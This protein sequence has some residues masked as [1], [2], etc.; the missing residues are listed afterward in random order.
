MQAVILAAGEGKRLWPLTLER[1]KPLVEVAGRPILEHIIDAFPSEIDEIIIIVGYKAD[2]IRQHFGNSYAGRR[3]KYMEQTAPTGTAHALALA[4]PLLGNSRFLFTY[5]DDLH[6]AGDIERALEHPL[7]ILAARHQDPSRFGV[8]ELNSDGTLAN[9]IEKPKVPPTNLISTG[10]MVLD[11]HIFDYE[12][13]RHESGEYYLTN[14]LMQLAK[15]YPVM[16]VEQDFWIPI[17]Y[18]EDVLRADE[19][20]MNL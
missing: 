14:P 12:P 2:M 3:I 18:P 19:I 15:D 7:S 5:G 11:S 4:K 13:A 6:G 10:V 20:L 16:V 8:I 17:G 9:I 1:P